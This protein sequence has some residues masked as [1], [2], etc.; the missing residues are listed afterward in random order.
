M[1]KLKK[2]WNKSSK[3]TLAGYATAIFNALVALDIDTLN[4]E[5]PSTYVKLFGI[6]VLPILGGHMSEIKTN[7]NGQV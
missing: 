6:I 3:A 1:T 4:W 7:T 2:F 5:L